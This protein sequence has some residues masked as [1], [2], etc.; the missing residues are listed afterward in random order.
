MNKGLKWVSILTT[1]GMFLVLIAG[2]LVTKT[3]SGQGCG[4]TWPLCHGQFAP[5]DS[6]ESIIEYSHRAISGVVGILV[7]VQSVWAWRKLG[8]KPGVKAFAFLGFFFTF[9]Q[10]LLGAAQVVWGQSSAVLALHFGFSLTAFA[11]VLLLTIL[12]FEGR[13]IQPQ[14]LGSITKQLRNAIWWLSVYCYIVVY[15]GAYVRHTKSGLGCVSWPKCNGYWIP[16][17]IGSGSVAIQFVHR[18]AA[19]IFLILVVWLT[20]V[21]VKYYRVR[22]DL[23]YGSI[24]LLIFTILQVLSGGYVVL[25]RLALGPALLHNTIIAG[26]FGILCYMCFQTLDHNQAANESESK[27]GAI[28]G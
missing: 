26:L 2:S 1:I 22:K 17:L 8:D 3:G 21:I 15:L 20:V 23:Y 13:M 11:S 25:A 16:D 7:V 12:V 9:L 10:A 5:L 24:A 28:H 27:K 4:N 19:F 14:K 18:V 6:L